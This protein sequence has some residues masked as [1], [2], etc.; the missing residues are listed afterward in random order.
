MY[1]ITEMW[2]AVYASKWSCQVVAN[3]AFILLQT[4][5][6]L[7]LE[8]EKKEKI[9][10]IYYMYIYVLPF[11]YYV[12]RLNVCACACASASSKVRESI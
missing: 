1:Y 8:E 6:C 5:A 2:C 10:H 12:P 7:M 4:H 3:A 9:V 11:Y